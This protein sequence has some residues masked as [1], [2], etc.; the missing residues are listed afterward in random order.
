MNNKKGY[1]LIEMIIYIAIVTGVLV[2]ASS[3]AWNIIN[4]K[5]KSQAVREVQE[6]GRFIMEK[7]TQGIRAA[8]NVTTV[9]NTSLTLSMKDANLN[10]IV[11]E[12][13]YLD[14]VNN[15]LKFT[16]S[17]LTYCTPAV[18]C[19]LNSNQVKITNLKF[20]NLSSGNKTQNIKIN[21]TIEHINPDQRP[22]WQASTNLESTVELRDR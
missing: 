2:M 3:F 8:Y 14:L 1:T 18:P 11:T 15:S 21:L 12:V 5:S 16:Q 22:E 6:N 10:P 17:N 13:F 20:T 19:V 4:N 7:L 9:T